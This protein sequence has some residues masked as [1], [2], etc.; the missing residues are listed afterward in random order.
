MLGYETESGQA[1][2]IFNSAEVV[3]YTRILRTIPLTSVMHESNY[4]EH[5]SG[6]AMFY[7]TG[8]LAALRKWV[9]KMRGS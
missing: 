7:L 6:L 4:A 9:V 1:G 5:L 2:S 3:R 8:I